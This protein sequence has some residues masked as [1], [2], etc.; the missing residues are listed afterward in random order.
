MVL[1]AFIT[2][3]I[4]ATITVLVIPTS[5]NQ[6]R[7]TAQNETTRLPSQIENETKSMKP[8]ETTEPTEETESTGMAYLLVIGGYTT[9]RPKITPLP[10]GEIY[11]VHIYTVD[12][13]HVTWNKGGRFAPYHWH[14]AG[15][16]VQG[17]NVF[18]AGGVAVKNLVQQN[19]KSIIY[20]RA[21]K[22][23]LRSDTWE[24]LP[25]I[26][27]PSQPGEN[28]AVY[29]IENQLYVTDGDDQVGGRTEPGDAL[30]VKLNLSDTESGWTREHAY[31]PYHVNN[32]DP[33]V[34]GNTVYIICKFGLA[35]YVSVNSFV[36]VI[37]WTYGETVWTSVANMNVARQ[38]H[39]TVTDGISSIWVVGGCDPDDCWPD[40]FI[41]RYNVENN[42]WTM[43]KHVPN[44]KKLHYKIQVC[45]FWQGYIYVIFSRKYERG[46]IPRFHV[47]NTKTGEWHVDSTRIMLS[48]YASMSA[49]VTL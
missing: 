46:L 17:D 40:G 30:T 14:S 39:G 6:V 48:A 29:I 18:L 10:E 37:S 16:A 23:N 32:H 42:T 26:S 35:P 25:D 36:K 44:I 28:P 11:A 47:Y 1:S 21:A 27:D 3:I 49:I 24:L 22:Y 33:V 45:S 20:Q 31:P 7:D 43:L 19:S 8:M 34:V 12:K 15:I 38:D 13:G 4:V 9:P 5:S 41:E 2:T